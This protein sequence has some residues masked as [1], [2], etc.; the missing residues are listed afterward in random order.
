MKTADRKRR[1]YSIVLF[2]ISIIFILTAYLNYYYQRSVLDLNKRIF[3]DD[4]IKS[5]FSF[6]NIYKPSDK[7]IR[8]MVVAL[9][10]GEKF[11]GLLG[12]K[13][14]NLTESH[15]FNIMVDPDIVDDKVKEKYQPLDKSYIT[16]KYNNFYV[17]PNGMVM[18]KY[19]IHVPKD[20]RH[21]IYQGSFLLKQID[22]EPAPQEG[23][24]I[25]LSLAQ[26]IMLTLEITDTPQTYIYEDQSI[27][28]KNI[29]LKLTLNRVR[30]IIGMLLGLA[31]LYIVVLYFKNKPKTS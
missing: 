10:P 20:A 21:G 30:Y 29:A 16:F 7:N 3:H 2:S 5:G 26:G 6:M 4:R 27:Q 11:N 28:A 23:G 18:A 14:R 24:N 31:A 17:E 9:R 15:T 8:G 13:N 12:I 19:T 1:L 25:T 22:T